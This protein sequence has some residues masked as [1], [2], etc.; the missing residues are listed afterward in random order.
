MNLKQFALLFVPPSTLKYLRRE[1]G[2]KKEY[3]IKKYGILVNEFTKTVSNEDL[4][5]LCELKRDFDIFLS[6]N[7]NINNNLNDLKKNFENITFEKL[8][9]KRIELQNIIN[10]K[11]KEKENNFLKSNQQK[12][13]EK[14][15]DNK[16]LN[17]YLGTEENM[18]I[19]DKNQ[20]FKYNN[21]IFGNDNK[22]KNMKNL[23]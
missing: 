2:K 23:K 1:E 14:N 19:F 3:S 16:N 9:L 11:I 5:L 10:Q 12:M 8:I 7:N 21:D 15:L 17:N 20:K 22:N 18:P 4:R 6:E 13:R